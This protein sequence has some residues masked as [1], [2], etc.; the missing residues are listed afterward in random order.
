MLPFCEPGDSYRSVW[1][2]SGF[3]RCFLDLVGGI[4]AAGI[5]YVLGVG[6]IV[7]GK[8]IAH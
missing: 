1:T 8:L 6:C 2:G 3:S 5:L 7:L 4:A